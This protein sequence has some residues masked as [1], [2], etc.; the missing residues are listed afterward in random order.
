MKEYTKDG[1]EIVRFRV[2]LHLKYTF[3]L[4]PGK[5]KV[6]LRFDQLKR[7]FYWLKGVFVRVGTVGSVTTD[8]QEAYFGLDA[9]GNFVRLTPPDYDE[10]TQSLVKD[11]C[12]SVSQNMGVAENTDD[13]AIVT[14]TQN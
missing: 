10:R 12:L 14:L 1:K 9:S 5:R 4:K 2:P 6:T 11:I 13:N 8:G 7:L 3:T